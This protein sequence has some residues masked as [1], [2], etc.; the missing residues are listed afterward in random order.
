MSVD[1]MAAPSPLADT[2]RSLRGTAPALVLGLALLGLLFRAE[3]VAA[4]H[5]WN[6]STAYN[7]CFLVVP[8]AAYLAWDR[9]A[10]L[11]GLAAHPLPWTALL[12][13]PLAAAWLVAERLGIME[14]RQLVAVT[15]LQLLVLGTLGW[16]LWWALSGPML[17][18]YFM[19]PFGEFLVPKL[20]DVTTE[21]V[22]HGLQILQIPAFIDGYVIEIPE[23]VFFIAEACAGL[24][25]LI[26]SIAFGVLYALMM[27]RS[28]GRRAAFIVA[29]ILI[30]IV[31]NGFR[32]L[33]IVWLGHVIGSAQAAAADHV[34]Y[35]WI[36][37]SAVIMLLILVGLPFREDDRAEPAPLRD[38]A[39]V[40]A[41][42]R[43]AL[44]AALALALL[45][46]IGP[47][48]AAAIDRHAGADLAELQP[49]D[50][51]PSCVTL[52]SERLTPPSPSN[53]LLQQRVQ[54]D[55]LTLDLRVALF[56][57]RSTAAPVLGERRRLTRVEAVDEAM[58]T[59]VRGAADPAVQWRVVQVA[60]PA[61]AIASAVW[62]D[63]KPVS[64]GLPMRVRM[65]WHSLSGGVLAPVVV[66]VTPAVDWS[67]LDVAAQRE[68]I[69]RL[70]TFLENDR[71]I[72]AQAAV[73]AA[74]H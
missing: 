16:R 71:S 47:A 59:T 1:T 7:H 44:I 28:P 37:F 61:Y 40:A 65:A 8:I 45:A 26:A 23:G 39:P 35:G 15:F 30:P 34:I 11:R 24:R 43:G 49:L 50:L 25:F 48:V 14:G 10:A 72:A 69:A 67:R 20:Q 52:T 4:V 9:R 42:L 2:W 68:A 55:D 19:V 70:S 33:G 3:I 66:T 17:Y 6:D 41:P 13:L 60:D 38:P 64:G 58:L 18:L 31:A 62:V 29:S 73:L 53:R 12:A 51:G 54:C 74:R 21:F 36:F 56:S 57:P 5:V 27:Y 22:R 46:G 63:G 32:A